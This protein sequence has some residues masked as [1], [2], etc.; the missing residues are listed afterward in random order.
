MLAA[1]ILRPD[2]HEQRAVGVY[3]VA[4][5]I[6]HA[7]GDDAVGFAGRG[8]DRAAR[9]HAERVDAAAARQVQRQL[10]IRRAKRRMARRRAVLRGVD[11][12]LRMLNARADGEGLLHQRDA[13]R[14]QRLKRVAGAVADSED[15]GFGGQFLFALCVLIANGGDMAVRMQ[16]ARQPRA[17]AHLAAQLENP[18]AHGLDHAAELIR[19]DVRLGV[20]ENVVRCA[21]AHKCAQ[22][23]L[24]ARVFRARVELAVGKRAR[25][26]LAE[27]HVG[28]RGKGFRAARPVGV[29]IAGA[30]IH[31]LAAFQHDGACA[32]FGQR[33]CG[34]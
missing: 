2:A 21:E 13:A 8:D 10:V 20:N 19:A 11:E 26:A 28:G 27:L 17:E 6:A 33:Q 5:V 14:K 32:R 7:V 29:H 30:G 24:A 16:Y 4:G 3:A 9:A 18:H 23:V 34:K 31:V 25:A 22:N 12:A 1:E 15:D